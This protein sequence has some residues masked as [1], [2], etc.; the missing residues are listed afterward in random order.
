[1]RPPP[2]SALFPYTTLFRSTPSASPPWLDARARTLLEAAPREHDVA[3]NSTL[4]RRLHRTLLGRA[5]A[6]DASLDRSEEHTSELQSHVNLV[7]R[8]LPE[9]KTDRYFPSTVLAI[10]FS[11]THAA[12]TGICPLSLHD[13]LPIYAIGVAA[14]ARRTRAHVARSRAARARRGREQHAEPPPASHAARSRR[15]ARRVARQ[16]GRAHV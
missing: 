10:M 3:A 2:G 8:L 12:P 5:A 13:A 9:K 14:V 6:L 1:M 7:C 16:I 15:G 11:F 4:N